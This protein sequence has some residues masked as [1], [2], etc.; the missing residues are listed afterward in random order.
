MAAKATTA[1]KKRATGVAPGRFGR[2]EPFDFDGFDRFFRSEYAPAT[3]R[4]IHLGCGDGRISVY[5]ARHGYLVL[6]IDP[7]RDLLAS[8]RERAAMVGV[9][10][11]LMGG[12]PLGLPPLPEECYGLAVDLFTAS[13][14]GD[15]LPR[16]DYLRGILKLLRRNGIL[17]ASAPA[18]RRSRGQPADMGLFAFAGPFVS[19][20]TRAGFEVVYEGVQNEPAGEPRLVVHARKPD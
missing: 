11:E 9:E 12:D 19:D 20:F 17:I 13:A 14:L 18:P 8:A 10:I 1:S 3:C 2:E 4:C 7:N 16:E 5:L 6:G 15:G